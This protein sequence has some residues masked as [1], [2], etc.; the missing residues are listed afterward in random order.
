MMI[1]HLL[2]DIIASFA[3]NT[4][5]RILSVAML[6]ISALL[7]LW[8]EGEVSWIWAGRIVLGAA[9]LWTLLFVLDMIIN[10]F[11]KMHGEH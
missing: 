4:S 8:A 2:A 5:K 3:M 11:A 7:L 10:L 1:M 6:A 9:A